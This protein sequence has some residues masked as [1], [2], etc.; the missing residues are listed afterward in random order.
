MFDRIQAE[1]FSGVA[2][3][4]LLAQVGADGGDRGMIVLVLIIGADGFLE[5][6]TWHRWRELFELAHLVI[7]HRP[8]FPADGWDAR[9]PPPLAAEYESRRLAQPLDVHAR[10][11]GGIVVMPLTAL[12]ISASDIRARLRAGASPRYLLPDP[13]IEYIRA[14]ALYASRR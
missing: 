12:A 8:G 14:H 2:F 13:V 11:A 6:A 9:L 1:F 3:N 10:A 4:P 7:A 5:F